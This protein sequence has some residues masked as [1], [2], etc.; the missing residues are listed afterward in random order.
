MEF[1]LA[2]ET[3]SENFSAKNVKLIQNSSEE[4]LDVVLEMDDTLT[5]GTG[6]RTEEGEERQRIFWS[7]FP[8]DAVAANDKR[9]HGR[10]VSR[11]GDK[12]LKE[13]EYFLK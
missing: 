1:K 4:I 7:K 6:N 9:L 11:I 3:S 5:I 12:F 13:N 2:T 8:V 10:I